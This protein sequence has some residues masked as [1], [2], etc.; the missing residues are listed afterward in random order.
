[1]NQAY[2][3]SAPVALPTSVQPSSETVFRSPLISLR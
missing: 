1:M 2:A 3:N